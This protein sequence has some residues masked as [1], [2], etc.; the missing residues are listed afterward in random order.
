MIDKL[1]YFGSVILD[2]IVLI[3][4]FDVHKW[5]NSLNNKVAPILNRLWLLEING[6]YLAAKKL[7]D[8]INF[9]V[10]LRESGLQI[11]WAVLW[12]LSW[13]WIVLMFILMFKHAQAN[14]LKKYLRS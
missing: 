1:G 12:V 6:K 4:A 7:V 2:V 13:I 14:S 5:V 8:Q 9:K 10:L 11:G 3:F